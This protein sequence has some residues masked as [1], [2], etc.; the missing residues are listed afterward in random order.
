[1]LGGWWL[2]AWVVR[3]EVPLIPERGVTSNF[4]SAQQYFA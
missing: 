4:R 3:G 1:M 2:C